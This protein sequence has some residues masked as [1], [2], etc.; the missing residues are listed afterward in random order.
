MNRT[1]PR[2]VTLPL[3]S[4]HGAL[5]LGK[6]LIAVAEPLED[7]PRFLQEPLS[8]LDGNLRG[9]R[10]AVQYRIQLQTAH[11]TRQQKLRAD[12]SVHQA[13]DEVL[14]AMRSYVLRVAVIADE[15]EAETTELARTLIAPV[16]A[17]ELKYGGH[18]GTHRR[19]RRLGSS[20]AA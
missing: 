14:S 8:R 13:L 9:L 10:G 3:L 5:T 6:Q 19:T 2:K 1:A 20:V 15:E 16:V 7:H 4:V 11:P 12:V 17:W 18:V